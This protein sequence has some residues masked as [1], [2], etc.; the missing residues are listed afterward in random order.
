MSRKNLLEYRLNCRVYLLVLVGLLLQSYA[1]AQANSQIP[2]V[3]KPP[4]TLD[5]V[6][7]TA[8]QQDYRLQHFNQQHLKYVKQSEGAD[9]LPDPVVFAGMQNLPVDS[10]ALDQEPMT[11]LRL[12]VRQMFPKGDSLDLK[13]ESALLKSEIQQHSADDYWRERKK[14]IEQTWFEAVFWQQRLE[15]LQIDQGFLEQM[16]DFIKSLYEVGSRTQSDLIGAELELIKLKEQS[17]DARQSYDLHRRNL[18]SL[19]NQILRDARLSTNEHFNQA[20]IDRL[21]NIHVSKDSFVLHPRVL[22]HET[23]LAL[24]KTQ[25][26]LLEQD[27]EPSWGVEVSY[28]LRDG[29]NA[30]GSDRPDFFSAGISVAVPFFSGGR[31]NANID[32]EKHNM[33]S[34]ALQRDE[35]ALA[36]YHAFLSQQQQLQR[37][38]EQRQLYV[39][40]IVPTLTDQ[41]ATAKQAYESDKGSLQLVINLFLKEQDA[42][43]MVTRLR[44]QEKKI[45]SEMHFLLGENAIKKAEIE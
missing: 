11:N 16:R 2:G 23:R 32:A 3:Q 36:I 6:L 5:E 4:L 30:D 26:N 25:V 43:V 10:F 44:A 33:S 20:E 24:S 13:E 22:G 42:K 45:V 8:K 29:Q 21:L 38:V 14:T 40:Q 17:I 35:A 31:Q 37:T 18:D 28:G 19:A 7:I 1:N 34:M 12:G 41:R 39:D 27:F 15:L 9:Y